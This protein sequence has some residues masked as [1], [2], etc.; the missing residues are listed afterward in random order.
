MKVLPDTQKLRTFET[1][2]RGYDFLL[3][4]DF[5]ATC[6]ELMGSVS[7]HQTRTA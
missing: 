4:I 5:E 6:E 3:C 2:I 7:E 1:L